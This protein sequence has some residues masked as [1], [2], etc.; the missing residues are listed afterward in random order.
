MKNIKFILL[1][2]VLLYTHNF[3]QT[4]QNQNYNRYN[5]SKLSEFWQQI[6]DIF[7]DPNFN[8]SNWGVVIKSLETGEYLYKR[9]EDKL[10]IPASNLKLITTAA[11]LIDLG[12][13]YKYKTDIYMDGKIDGSV[14]KGNLVVQGIGDPTFSERFNKGNIYQV[15]SN[16]ADSLLARNIDE[17][18]G[19]LIGDDNL[20]DDNGFGNGWSL[21]HDSYWYS[22]PTSAICFNDNCIEISVKPT[23]NNNQATLTILPQTRYVTV[24]NKVKTG[25]KGSLTSLDINR[26][27]G[28]NIITVYGKIEEGSEEKIVYSTV[29]N[30][31]QFAMV[32][33]KDVL[34]KKGIVVRGY[35]SDI[36]MEE[37]PCDYSKMNVLFTYESVPLFDII[38]IMNK[39]SQNF[40]AEQLLKTIGLEKENFGSI[41]NGVKAEKKL[42]KEMGINPENLIIADGS[43]L[44]WLNLITPRQIINLLTYMYRNE[45][46]NYFYESLPVAGVDGTLAN[47]MKR[48]KAENNVRAKTGYNDGV[49]SL[50]GY[51]NTA[52]NEPI[53]FS[54]IV[55]NF[56]VPASLADNLQDQVCVR[57][58]N[59]S[60]K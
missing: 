26:E 12:P 17:I 55:N 16:W 41:E 20:F 1:L 7:S 37:S 21:D 58:A 53:A 23:T 39:D 3:G 35:A 24:I 6:D 38:K 45:N 25:P 51:V 50:S 11:G 5:S 15:F 10:F 52:D 2:V 4:Y 34:Q 28:T 47:R 36:D 29:N 32:V 31:T 42:L 49:R 14:L 40:Y 13:N 43:G 54:I 18:S 60:R 44:S 59:F 22:A 30:P 8:S 9:N 19:N 33:L 27:R 57:L 46:F 56:I 48:S